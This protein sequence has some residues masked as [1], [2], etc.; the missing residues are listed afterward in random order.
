MIG[1]YPEGNFKITSKNTMPDLSICTRP[2][3]KKIL[4]S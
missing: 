2:T 3:T 4:D 1:Y